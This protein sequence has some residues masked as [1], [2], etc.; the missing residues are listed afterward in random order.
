MKATRKISRRS[1]LGSIG[2]GAAAA[3][4]LLTLSGCATLGSDSDPYDPIGGGGGGRHRGGGRRGGGRGEGG[5][6]GGGHGRGNGGCSDSDS[7]RNA[8]PA[9]RG[10]C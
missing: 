9:G 4:A 5:G 6:H 1:F 10:R 8:D 7:G 3:G 2:G